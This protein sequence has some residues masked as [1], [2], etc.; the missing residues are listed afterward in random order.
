MAQAE[1]DQESQD[2]LRDLQTV[3]KEV[4]LPTLE[5]KSE[6]KHNITK[7]TNQISN[8]L[9]QAYGNV[10]IYVPPITA[11]DDVIQRDQKMLQSFQSA[12]ED[13]TRK[14]TE[15]IEKEEKKAKERQYL[16]ASGETEFWSN[17]SA[18]FNTLFQ[19]LQMPT[20]KKILQ[21]LSNKDSTYS[22]TIE[23]YQSE[24]KKFVK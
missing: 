23:S 13:W 10:T 21:L 6:I 3:I 15:T 19:Q 17:R 12:V 5:T 11:S 24:Y 16:T 9:T 14:I 4:F 2:R 7:F 20:V 8:A 1:G 22:H 18:T